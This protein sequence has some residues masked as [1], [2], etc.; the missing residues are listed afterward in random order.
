MGVFPTLPFT[1]SVR[2]FRLSP[3][4]LARRAFEGSKVKRAVSLQRW[5]ASAVAI[6]L[7]S[8]L[9][10]APAPVLAGPTPCSTVGGVT[11]CATDQSQ[12]ATQ[13]GND[14][15]LNVNSL[16]TNIAPAA[17]TSGVSLVNVGKNGDDGDNGDGGADITVNFT[18]THSITS[19]GAPGVQGQS[20]GGR[21]SDGTAV[22]HTPGVGG[23]G[24]AES[25]ARMARAAS[26]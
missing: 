1:A 9:A 20:K 4:A 5:A 6:A 14:T 10:L 3:P 23:S 12:G 19:A 21:G 7:A 25:A 13:I 11:T 16:T 2:S 8:G 24:G 17:G 26:I 18:D 15:T 22:I